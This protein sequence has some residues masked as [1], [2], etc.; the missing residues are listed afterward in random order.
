M[1]TKIQK[2]VFSAM[3]LAMAYAL[4]FLT[5]QIPNIGNMLCPMHI[6]VLLCGFICGWPYGLAVGF[7]SPLLRSFILAMPPLFP[8]AFAMAFE[9]AAYGIICGLL[10]KYLPKKIPYIYIELII[11]MLAGRIVW[12]AARA[13]IAGVQ[14]NVFGL[15]VFWT[16]GFINALP[17][18]IIQITLIPIIVIV[19]EKN[20]M[21]LNK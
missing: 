6:P 5:G 2:T 7:A 20:R 19:M 1:K 15:T 12:G 16:D 18:I 3:F 13:A 9:L 10:Y 8:H 11:A 4:P 17:G 21:I 14:G